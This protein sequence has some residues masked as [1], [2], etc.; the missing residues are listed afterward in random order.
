MKG[1]P[2]SATW[3]RHSIA[4]TSQLLRIIIE[5]MLPGPVPPIKGMGM[6]AIGIF[7]PI[8]SR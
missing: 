5:I 3:V 8:S 6:T 7:H 2:G 4:K 1:V